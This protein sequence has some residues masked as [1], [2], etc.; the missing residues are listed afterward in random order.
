[1]EEL[2]MAAGEH[3]AKLLDVEAAHICGS[4]AAGIALMAAACMV[5]T[6]KGRISRLPDTGGMRN[7]FIVQKSHLNPFD[8]AVRVAGGEFI[9]IEA[10]VKHLIEALD[11]E[12]AAVYYTFAWF[13]TGEALPLST[14][15]RISHRADVPVIVDAAAEV[16][17]LE[18]FSRLT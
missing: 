5:G 3:V 13:C 14:V 7:K 17:P 6:D 9:E 16:P 10:D 15:T 8:Q 11:D 2:H 1:M 4:A 12:I 18:N